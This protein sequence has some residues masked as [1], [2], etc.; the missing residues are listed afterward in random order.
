LGARQQR[1]PAAEDAQEGD[2]RFC[3]ARSGSGRSS[4]IFLP[5]QT[6]HLPRVLR[7]A[8]DE[9]RRKSGGCRVKPAMARSS[10]IAAQQLFITGLGP[11]NRRRNSSFLKRLRPDF[12]PTNPVYGSRRLQVALVARGD[13]R[14]GRRRVPAADAGKLRVCGRSGPKRNTSRKR[15]SPGTRV[16]TLTFCAAKTID[17]ANQVWAA[18]HN[19]HTECGR[20][21]CYLVAIIDWATRRVLSWRLCRT[22]WTAGFLRRSAE[23]GSRPVRQGPASSNTDQRA[24]PRESGGAQFTQRGVPPRYYGIMGSRSAWTDAGR[25][26]DKHLCVER[27]WW[28]VEARMVYLP[29]GRQRHRTEAQFS[30]SFFDWL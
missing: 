13:F 28:T 21:F 20:D 4:A 6:R 8:G 29:P 16:S 2:R 7:R 24:C 9:C 14:V 26:H 17:R 12:S 10:G 23:R 19:L 3:T 30:A 25:C 1:A 11:E 22:R 5:G 27:L 18:D 15:A